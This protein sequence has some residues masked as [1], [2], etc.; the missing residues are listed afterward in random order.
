[1]CL[2]ATW[3]QLNKVYVHYFLIDHKD[4]SQ[5]APGSV[6]GETHERRRRRK[7]WW[8]RWWGPCT[9]ATTFCICVSVIVF[10][11]LY[12]MGCWVDSLHL[13]DHLVYLYFCNCIC[14]FVVDGGCWVDSPHLHDLLRQIDQWSS[15]ISRQ[16]YKQRFTQRFWQF[17]GHLVLTLSCFWHIGLDEEILLT[18]CCVFF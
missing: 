8:R 14:I 15:Q 1:M 9:C 18:I 7:G 4:Q 17:D 11:F 16:G 10:V 3:E 13:R 5:C 2:L 12:F 6:G